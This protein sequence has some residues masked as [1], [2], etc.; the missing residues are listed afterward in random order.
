MSLKRKLRQIS[1]DWL[2]NFYHLARGV[3]AATLYG[4]PG[5][6]LRVIGITGTNGKTTTAHLITSILQAGG[7]KVGMATT[8]DFQIGDSL[9]DNNLKMTT[10]SPFLLQK[11]LSQMVKVGCEDAV[12]E[13]TSIG[14]D[15]HRLWG[16]PF[17]AARLEEHTS[18]LQ[19]QSNLVCPLL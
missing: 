17:Q 2:V 1:P 5:R 8:V 3:V 4:F 14:L 11:L 6:K 13:V 9:I 12:I 18:E 19:S 10:V 16:I 7:H 15:Q